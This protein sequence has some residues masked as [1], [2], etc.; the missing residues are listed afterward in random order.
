MIGDPTR[1]FSNGVTGQYGVICKAM[2]R[3]LAD[4]INIRLQCIPV[5]RLPTWF[6]KPRTKNLIVCTEETLDKE[7]CE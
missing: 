7:L 6:F 5:Q 3:T 2:S 1:F 4:R